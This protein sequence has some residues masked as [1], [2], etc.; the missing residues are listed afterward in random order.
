MQRMMA[1]DVGSKTVGVAISDPLGIFA[2]GLT[3]VRRT[4]LK[5]D[6]KALSDLIEMYN[7][8]LLVVGYPI[9]M[10]GTVGDQAR[11]VDAFIEALKDHCSV[12]IAL[13]DERLTTKI[14]QQA[15]SVI[16]QGYLD[17]RSNSR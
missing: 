11:S 5:A 12:P 8:S 15:A 10:N 13:E 2:Q 7:P 6:L 16:L 9:N 17:R 14:A 4:N 3:T 1:L